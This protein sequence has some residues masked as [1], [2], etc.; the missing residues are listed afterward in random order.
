MTITGH[1]RHTAT[2]VQN[3]LCLLRLTCY[4]LIPLWAVTLVA[5]INYALDGFADTAAWMGV[6]P[7]FLAGLPIFVGI[8]AT[9]YLLIAAR[10]QLSVSRA[11]RHAVLCAAGMVACEGLQFGLTHGKVDHLPSFALCNLVAFSIVP[12]RVTQQVGVAGFS[13]ALPLMAAVATG[14]P[15]A[16]TLQMVA[17]SSLPFGAVV[18]G[19]VAFYWQ[20]G[21]ARMRTFAELKLARRTAQVERQKN[22]LERRR[23]FDQARTQWLG[24]MAQFLRHEMRNALVGATTSLTL[25]QRRSGIP[26][27]DAYM[28]RT[29]RALR[30]MGTLLESVSEA[31]SI[32]ST[33]SKEKRGMVDLRPIVQEQIEVYRSVYP[34]KTF[35]FET[36]GSDVTILG[37]SERCI[38]ILDNLV[39]NAMDYADLDTPIGVSCYRIDD[40]AVLSVTNRGVTISNK[41]DIFA[42]FSSFRDRDEGGNHLGIGLYMV[43]LIADRYGGHVEARDLTGGQGAEFRV[44]L[45]LVS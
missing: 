26:E 16:N 14:S 29:R 32:E 25:L 36:D 23:Q 27:N 5:H 38:E 24:Q 7:E 39:S 13:F 9:S 6:P 34:D 1:P 45:P 20:V 41:T 31:T 11:Q 28:T 33:L 19:L 4:A 22:E 15:P 42:P 43:K 17:K 21:A 37:R 8:S 3:N 40:H 12:I 18:L 44:A 35:T 30:V 2:F 10:G